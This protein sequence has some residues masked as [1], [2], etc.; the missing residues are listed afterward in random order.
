M[1]AVHLRSDIKET[2]Q[3]PD[4]IL[5]PLERQLIA[6]QLCRWQ[7]YIMKLC[8]WLFVLYCRNCPKDDPNLGTL[9]PFWGSQGR[10]RTLVDGSLENPYRVLV[11]CDWTSFSISYDWGATRQN[12]SKLAAGVDQF[13]PRFQGKG[14][15]RCQY[16]VTTQKAIIALQLLR[17]QWLNFFI[18]AVFR[19]FV[20]QALRN[21]CYSDVSRRRFLNEIAIVRTF[22]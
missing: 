22:S 5:I 21:V 17:W 9:F 13:E 4:I 15:S 6:L 14:S 2:E 3:P 10:R 1:E 7:F 8:S 11:K 19:H 16:I 12:V 18:S 20:G